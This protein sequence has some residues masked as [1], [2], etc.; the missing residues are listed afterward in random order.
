MTF[1]GLFTELSSQGNLLPPNPDI[2]KFNKS[3]W[4]S[5][6]LKQKKMAK[7]GE[8]VFKYKGDKGV[9]SSAGKGLTPVARDN[10][11]TPEITWAKTM[12][13]QK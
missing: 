1:L 2:E 5:V 9:L 3:Q 7:G 8:M 10:T 13:R 6:Y 4:R 12:S 11:Q